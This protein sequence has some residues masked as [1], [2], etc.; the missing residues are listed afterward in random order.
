M[1]GNQVTL[2][3]CLSSL[4]ILPPIFIAPEPETGQSHYARHYHWVPPSNSLAA[5]PNE[6][7]W[8]D[9]SRHP[10]IGRATSRRL[11]GASNYWPHSSRPGLGVR[12]GW[13]TLIIPALSPPAS[14]PQLMSL[15]GILSLSLSPPWRAKSRG[16]VYSSINRPSQGPFMEAGNG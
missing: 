3:H 5:D 4:N 7:A 14:P 8:H 12:G 10:T 9:S 13:R 6:R 16:C 15:P 2:K 11:V 1:L